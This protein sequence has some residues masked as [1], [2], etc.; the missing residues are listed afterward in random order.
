M[1]TSVQIVF[2]CADPD[3]IA[4]FWATALGYKFQDPP[5]GFA[6]WEDFLVANHFPKEMWNARSAVVD[7]QGTGPRLFF[8]KVPEPKTVKNRVHL[9]LNISGGFSVPLEERK[10]LV[11]AEVERLV[12]AG[13]TRL[14]TGEENGEYWVVMA[15]PEDNE[16]CVH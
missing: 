2:D 10:R 11:K 9:D 14:R 5:P 15:D 3:R 7:P 8:Q 1:A 6:T 4:D 12:S 16:F 13:A